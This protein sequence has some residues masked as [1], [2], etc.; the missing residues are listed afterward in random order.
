MSSA[1]SSA[2]DGN[3]L[4]WLSRELAELSGPALGYAFIFLV[5]VIWVGGSFLVTSLEAQGLSPFLLTYVCNALFVVLLPVYFGRQHYMYGGVR[6]EELWG[7]LPTRGVPTSGAHPGPGSGSGPATFR[8]LRDVDDDDDFEATAATDDDRARRR[9]HSAVDLHLET[10]NSAP[11]SAPHSA[12]R[13]DDPDDAELD[14]PEGR[15]RVVD[16][17]RAAAIIAPVWFL[18]QLAFNYS[19]AYT[20]VT[21]NSILSTSSSVFTFALSVWLVNERYSP[22]RLAAVFAYVLGSALV[23]LADAGDGSDAGTRTA[24]DARFGDFLT[25]VAAA[26]YAGYTAGI[27]YHLPD[28][29]K[30]SMLLFL[31]AV[32]AWNLVGV[33][34]FMVLARAFGFLP[35]LYA[36]LNWTVF[37]F[38]VGKGLFDNVLSDYL[39]AR[40]VLLTSPTVASVGLSMQIPMAAAVEAM[41]GRARWMDTATAAGTMLVGCGLVMAGFLGVVYK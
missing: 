26:L 2:L 5:C 36:N 35:D 33:G 20:S 14:A 41:M 19:L 28:D 34:A 8:R 25:V 22:E 16:T 23:T 9:A 1:R 29:P 6:W 3:P 11:Q 4:G 27:R 13:A 38:A 15:Q 32:G 7:G 24:A 18:A 40:A 31:G 39:W 12:R 30:V 21:S 17:V 37:G 10:L